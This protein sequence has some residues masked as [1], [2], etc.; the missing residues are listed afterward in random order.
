MVGGRGGVGGLTMISRPVSAGLNWDWPTGPKLGK[1]HR[2]R[3]IL[4]NR[5]RAN[6]VVAGQ[7]EIK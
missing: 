4:T 3:P 7:K 5:S 2:H 6:F 1:I